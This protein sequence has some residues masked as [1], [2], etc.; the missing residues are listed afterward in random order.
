MY[1]HISWLLHT[2]VF[3]QYIKD[4]YAYTNFFDVCQE[5]AHMERVHFKQFIRPQVSLLYGGIHSTKLWTCVC[6]TK[7]WAPSM[8]LFD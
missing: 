8:E 4:F 2:L 3:T 1:I 5:T 6:I 7:P